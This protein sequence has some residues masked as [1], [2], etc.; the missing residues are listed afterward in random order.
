[1][2]NEHE[3]N[4]PADVNGVFNLVRICG[5]TNRYHTSNEIQMQNS[6]KQTRDL[7]PPVQ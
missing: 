1:M 4:L 2:S 5:N 7:Q 6:V 3:V